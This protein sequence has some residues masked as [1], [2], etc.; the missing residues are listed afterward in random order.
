MDD[1]SELLDGLAI[2]NKM[3]AGFDLFDEAP[4][5]AVGKIEELGYVKPLIQISC[6]EETAD[7]LTENLVITRRVRRSFEDEFAY[8]LEQLR[9][10]RIKFV[11]ADEWCA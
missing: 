9:L 4:L 10:W 2:K 1:Q 7:I 11:N 5:K 6:D 3:S 8:N